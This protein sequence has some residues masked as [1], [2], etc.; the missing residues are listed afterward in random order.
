MARQ[1]TIKLQGIH[2]SPYTRKML[3]VL[4]FRRLPYRFIVNWPQSPDAPGNGEGRSALPTPKVPL[5]PT[6]YLKDEA[7]ELQAVTDTTPIIRRLESQFRTRSI[8]PDNPV[9]AF[10]NYVLEDYADEWLTRCM[11]HYRWHF[12]ADIEKAGRVL[13]LYVRVNQ[14]PEML[15]AVSAA[16]TRRQVDRLHVVGSNETTAPVIEASYVRFLKLMESH[17]Q[18]HPFLLGGR[19]ASADFAMMGQLTCLTHFDPTPMRLCETLAP[20][21][22]AWVERLDDLS[23]YEVQEQG[24]LDA[25]DALPE[26]LLA[27]LGEVARTHMPQLIANGRA[28]IGKN[29]TFSTQ[30]DGCDWVQ[31]SFSYQLKCLRWTREEFQSLSSKDQASARAIL[32]KTGLSRLIDA[33]LATD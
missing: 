8:V 29:E 31:P 2:G 27:L 4:R 25:G 23:G 9:L 24:W 1:D 32:D 3:A 33:Q 11:F 15:D 7:G 30:I 20:R 28:V 12:A 14:S 26:T 13:P 6:V 17:L 5:L 10:L 19:P 16:F 22:Y 21:V 18:A